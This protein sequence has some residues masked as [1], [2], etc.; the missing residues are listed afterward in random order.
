MQT[1]EGYDFFSATDEVDE[2]T[3]AAALH[4]V[5]L[6]PKVRDQLEYQFV[7]DVHVWSYTEAK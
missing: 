4:S 1:D 6:S 5:G 2:D 3:F 7:D